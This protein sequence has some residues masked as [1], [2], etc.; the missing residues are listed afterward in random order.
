[1]TSSLPLSTPFVH[2]RP[3]QLFVYIFSSFRPRT[4]TTS[5]IQSIFIIRFVIFSI[6]PLHALQFLRTTL[7]H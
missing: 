4:S 6:Y 7:T 1:M 3:V 5:C 2:P